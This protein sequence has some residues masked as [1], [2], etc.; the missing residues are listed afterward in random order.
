LGRSGTPGVGESLPQLTANVQVGDTSFFPSLNNDAKNV[1]RLLHSGG[2]CAV[3]ANGV[4]PDPALCV[5]SP[6]F[7]NVNDLQGGA[8]D[9]NDLDD[10][11]GTNNNVDSVTTNVRGTETDLGIDKF[12]NGVLE[13]GVGPSGQYTIAVTNFGPD[14]ITPA[15][16]TPTITVTDTEPA[17]IQFVA[18]DAATDP[19]WICV[20]SGDLLPI[21]PATTAIKCDFTGTLLN[22][23]TSNIILNV[24]VTGNAGDVVSNTVS[25]DSGLFNFDAIPGNDAD[26]DITAIVAPPVASQEKFLLSVST[27][28]VSGNTS[29]GGLVGFKNDD[30][31]I[32][33]PVLDVATL[34]FD[35]AGL[36]FS[37]DDINAV[38]L[39]PNG[40]IILSPNGASS[41]GALNFDEGDLIRYDPIAGTAIM[42]FNGDAIF[43]NAD[44]NIDAVY[45]LD[46]G[47]IVFSTTANATIGGQS[48]DKSDLVEF[49]GV[50][51]SIY[52]S[53]ADSNVFGAADDVQ[54]DAAYI[55]VDNADATLVIDTF[56]F[57]TDDVLNTVGADS[58]SFGRDDLVELDN[59]AAPAAST[60]QTVFLGNLPL[61]VFSAVDPARRLDAVHIL[62]DGYLGHFA[63]SQSQAGSACEAGKITITKHQGVSHVIDTDY[64]G[65]IEITTSTNEGDWSIDT[66]SGTLVNFGSGAA[67]YTFVPGDNG[68][69]T[70]NLNVTEVP[71][72]ATSL[73]VDVSNGIVSE[74]G[75]E[76]PN[77]N[78]N[79]VVTPVTY[80]DEFTLAAFD[81]NDGTTGWEGNWVEIDGFDGVS[82]G[83]GAGPSAG[84]VQISGGKLSLTSN[85]STD[86]NFEPSMAREANIGL[87]TVTETTFLNFDYTYTSLNAT[88]SLVVEVSDDGGAVYATATTITGITGSTGSAIPV[89]IDLGSVGGALDDF[90]NTLIVRYRIDNGYT[91]AS[92][93]FIDNVEIATGTTD[94]GI[95]VIDH[96]DIEVISSGIACVASTITIRGHDANHF[97]ASPGN[98]LVINLSTS[99]GAGT[100]ASILAGAGALVDVRA[101]GLPTRVD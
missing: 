77:F 19:G 58:T 39:L 76:D 1:A 2:S 13:Q 28:L 35:N 88:D 64:F 93:I 87:F 99:T 97:P 71:P 55:R 67:R 25:V 3:T 11:S 96:F 21:D 92:T 33:D 69:V 12:V 85:P 95:G 89:S 63:I 10:K 59:T 54:V 68:Q 86:G 22:G 4:S 72:S 40:H 100:W 74:L 9:I 20:D 16:T 83:S 43:T 101:Q 52:L 24:E 44:E 82:A 65:S 66:G 36:G 41:I 62:E 29:I 8:I 91:L 45:V 6:Q 48:W 46:N 23:A 60:S 37:I 27:A 15:L 73:N 17:F 47:N 32:Y 61:G 49:D 7:D 78:F 56:V 31:I 81:N 14:N 70:L 50:N 51:A 18:I 84:N 79:L 75:T 80:R 57:S 90:G 42:L 98:G 30:L 26:T 34:F 38:H 53:G 5:V 94:C